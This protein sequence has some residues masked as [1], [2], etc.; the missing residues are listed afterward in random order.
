ML[1]II[2]KFYFLYLEVCKTMSRWIFWRKSGNQNFAFL[3]K[4]F[5]YFSRTPVQALENFFF[6]FVKSRSSAFIRIFKCQKIFIIG[7]SNIKRNFGVNRSNDAIW[8]NKK[9]PPLN[10]FAFFL[11]TIRGTLHFIRY[12]RCFPAKTYVFQMNA[13]LGKSF[14]KVPRH[15]VPLGTK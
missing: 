5:K 14:V 11:V 15:K 3:K 2:K 6:K 10:Q 9:P 12:G 7:Y 4:K 8:G 13:W 1:K